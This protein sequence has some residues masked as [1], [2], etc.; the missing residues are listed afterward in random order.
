MITQLASV[1][2]QSSFRY[3]NVV[4]LLTKL[5]CYFSYNY[6]RVQFFICLLFVACFTTA[7]VLAAR[8]SDVWDYDNDLD[9]FR[10]TCET[11]VLLYSAGW[12]MFASFG[13]II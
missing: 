11:V 6:C 5:L 7:L 8:S 1:F 4:C 12:I 10:A 13:K 3:H 9:R 2:A